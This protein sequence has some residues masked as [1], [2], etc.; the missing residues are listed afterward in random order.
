M[1]EALSEILKEDGYYGVRV[2]VAVYCKTKAMV[3][4]YDRSPARQKRK[5][6]QSGK[7]ADKNGFRRLKGKRGTDSSKLRAGNKHKT[8]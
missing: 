8:R 7:P 4:Q 3:E 6:K 2:F 5:A 1:P